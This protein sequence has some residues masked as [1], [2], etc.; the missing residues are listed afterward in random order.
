MVTAVDDAVKNITTALDENNMRD[1][2]ILIFSTG[3]DNFVFNTQ[4]LMTSLS[5]D[6]NQVPNSYGTKI[7]KKV[8]IKAWF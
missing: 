8:E 7:Q 1:N 5:L 3:T 6:Q 4:F 2:T